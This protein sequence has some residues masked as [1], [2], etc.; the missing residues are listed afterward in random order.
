MLLDAEKRA[1]NLEEQRASMEA[2]MLEMA[3][4]KPITTYKKESQYGSKKVWMQPPKEKE[5]RG[6]AKKM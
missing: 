2:Q 6:S 3:S 4:S 1:D 5:K